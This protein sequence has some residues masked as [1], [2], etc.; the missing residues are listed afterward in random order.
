METILHTPGHLPL[1]RIDVWFQDEARFGQQNQTTR[2]WA[3]TGSRPRAI[4]QQ[5][6]EYSYL[7][8]AVCPGNGKT[9]AL[10][11]PVVNKE[12]MAQHMELIS[13]VLPAM[14]K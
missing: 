12:I 7:F 13:K 11:S 1:D 10:I 9:E 6:F 3:E 14:Q 4:K 5:Q 2:L 8:G